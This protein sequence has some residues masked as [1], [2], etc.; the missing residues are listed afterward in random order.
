MTD[1]LGVLETFDETA[2]TI[3]PESGD[4]VTIERSLV[5]TGKPVPPR[6]STRLRISPEQLE[7]IC[8]RGWR[9]TTEQPLG[10]WTLRAAGGF[11]GRANSARVGGDPGLDT[12]AAVAAVVDFYAARGLPPMV[13][14]VLDSAWPAEFEGRGWRQARPGGQDALVQIA[15]VAQALR[16]ARARSAASTRRP[17]VAIQGALTYDWMTLYGRTAG[18]EPEAVRAVMESGDVVAFAQIGDPVVAIGRAVVTGDWMGLQAVEVAEAHR[19]RGL[20]G[21][22]V[23]ALLDWG[24]SRGALSAYLQTVADNTAALRLYERYGFVTHHVYR[25]LSPAEAS[26]V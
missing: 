23:D 20:A 7:R 15:S 11:T 10:E 22:V 5:V 18:L 1:V 14:V 8:E 21:H 9:A 16:L 13:Q 3:R 12:E 2:L 25:Y 6:A 26:N 17:D 19:R 24:A 4:V